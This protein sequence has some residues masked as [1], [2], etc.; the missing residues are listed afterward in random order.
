M[1]AE[2]AAAGGGGGGGRGCWLSAPRRLSARSG[3]VRKLLI[4][5]GMRRPAAQGWGGCSHGRHA[6]PPPTAGCRAP[7]AQIGPP[8]GCRN[9]PVTTLHVEEAVCEAVDRRAAEQQHTGQLARC[10]ASRRHLDV[11][12]VLHPARR[13]CCWALG[14]CP[15]GNAAWEANPKHHVQ[16]TTMRTL[17]CRWRP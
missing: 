6:L 9:P 3:A 8:R 12:H 7:P 13:R 1:A 4:A 5:R 16:Q 17:D 2:Q 11:L 10:R 15:S 14:V